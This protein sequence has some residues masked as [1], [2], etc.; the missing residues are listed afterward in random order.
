MIQ[1]KS[2]FITKHCAACALS[3]YTWREVTVDSSIDT[4][5]PQRCAYICMYDYILGSRSQVP[6]C[7]PGWRLPRKRKLTETKPRQTCCAPENITKANRG[8][9]DAKS[10]YARVKD[11]Y[12]YIYI[13]H[14]HTRRLVVEITRSEFFFSPKE[15]I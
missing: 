2:S 11:I 12:P 3:L 1:K 8:A 7:L 10:C 5:S 9:F 6:P 14:I 13:V 4:F 15:I